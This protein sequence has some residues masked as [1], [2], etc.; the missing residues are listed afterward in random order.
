M[1]KSVGGSL[2]FE[3]FEFSF[4]SSCLESLCLF[5]ISFEGT[6]FIEDLFMHDV[7]DIFVVI[8]GFVCA[9]QL[10]RRFSW[11]YSL[12]DTESSKILETHLQLLDRFRS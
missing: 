9:L 11:I 3:E 8:V 1:I 6:E 5:Q 10:F 12:Q 4:F 2:F 7:V